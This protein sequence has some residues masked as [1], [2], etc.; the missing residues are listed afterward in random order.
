M[1][2]F[3]FADAKLRIP[4]IF[5]DLTKELVTAHHFRK[6]FFV[7]LEINEITV[8]ELVAPIRQ[9]FR[10]NVCMGIDLQHKAPEKL[11]SWRITFNEKPNLSF[12]PALPRAR[13]WIF[14]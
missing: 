11:R 12:W 4:G 9:F 13:P 8:P 7:V 3:V 5:R 10:N 6:P 1:I 14:F 2:L